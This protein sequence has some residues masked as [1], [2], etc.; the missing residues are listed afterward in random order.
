M[1]LEPQHLAEPLRALAPHHLGAQA[2]RAVDLLPRDIP[3][4]SHHSGDTTIVDGGDSVKTLGLWLGMGLLGM[5]ASMTQLLAIVAVVALPFGVGWLLEQPGGPFFL[6]IGLAT[7]AGV[8]FVVLDERRR[9]Q[10]G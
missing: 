2:V 5:L 9:R 6:L 4:D 1:R 7:L 8:A 3:L 10:R